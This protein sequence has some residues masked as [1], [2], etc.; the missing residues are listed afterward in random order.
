MYDTANISGLSKVCY[1]VYDKKYKVYLG[2][3]KIMIGYSFFNIKNAKRY[4]KD[5]KLKNVEIHKLETIT[6]QKEPVVV[7]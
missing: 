2:W 4:I 5:N 1:R 6:I 7:N 3:Q